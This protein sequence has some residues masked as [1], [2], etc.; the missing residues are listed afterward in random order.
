MRLSPYFAELKSAYEA[1]LDDLMTDSAGHDVLARR[2]RDKR[3]QVPLLLPMIECNPEMVA[4]AFH[5]GLDFPHPEIFKQL[6]GLDPEDLPSWSQ[7]HTSVNLQPWAAMLAEIVLQDPFGDHFLV[8]T[9]CLEYLRGK[10]EA[11]DDR[12]TAHPASHG[13]DEE[14]RDDDEPDDRDLE[15]AGEDWLSQQGFDRKD[16]YYGT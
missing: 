10:A 2:L 11:A 7:L 5:G 15:E 16:P 6:A 14:R 1:E 3:K 13:H 12:P 8:I 4:V 9:A